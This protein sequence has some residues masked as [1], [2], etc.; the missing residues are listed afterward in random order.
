MDHRQMCCRGP[1][2]DLSAM[3][4]RFQVDVP[5]RVGLPLTLPLM[6]VLDVR[7][8][9]HSTKRP[10][11]NSDALEATMRGVGIGY[12][13]V[14]QERDEAA[15]AE[16]VARD[17]LESQPPVCLLGVR[18][19]AREC[20]RLRLAQRL[21]EQL[22]WAV[23]HL[24]PSADAPP[25]LRLLAHRHA[26]VY[27]RSRGWASHA[28]AV[29]ERLEREMGLSGTWQSRVCG[30]HPP[31]G[32]TSWEEWDRGRK[33]PAPGEAPLVVRLPWETSMLIVPGFMT[34]AEVYS[35]QQACL[36]GAIDY[37]QPRRQVRNPD[38][39]FTQFNEHHKEAWLCE[40][41][42]HRD[43]RRVVPPR[44]HPGQP[45]SPSVREVVARAAAAA[46]APFNGVMCR[47]EPPGVHL[48]DGPH[49]YATHCGWGSTT[50][51]LLPTSTASRGTTGAGGERWSPSTYP[52]RRACSWRWAARSR[53][54]GC[55]P[56]RATRR[57]CLSA[58]SSPSSSTRT[59]RS[60]RSSSLLPPSCSP[61]SSAPCPPW[62]SC[63]SSGPGRVGFVEFAHCLNRLSHP[64][65][66][67]RRC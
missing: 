55:T 16:A 18:A 26:E 52:W 62:Q 54:A 13:Y 34:K 37:D 59:P 33:F 20:P 48:K 63:P 67:P 3:C 42:D 39:S 10:W 32:S 1:V 65:G 58:S 27:A 15:W 43:T 25:A 44:A 24:Q 8:L 6:S 38:G 53:S 11:F 40:D 46:M 31:D 66:R 35:L 7:E 36:P 50:V 2:A 5:P 41:Y 29:A 49:T 56:S 57:R 4:R 17:V 45:L 23:V 22:G 21:E 28:A 47:W 60:E 51:V 19:L 30:R 14:G 12:R 64:P 9:D 61:P